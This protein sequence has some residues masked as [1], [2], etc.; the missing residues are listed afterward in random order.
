MEEKKNNK[1]LIWL[2]VILIILI[3]G[4]IGFIVYDN[5]KEDKINNI[6]TTTR[7]EEANDTLEENILRRDN[8]IYELNNK[9]HTI[10][11]LYEK[12]NINE[13]NKINSQ[14][15]DVEEA[16]RNGDY[17]Y[18]IIYTKILI[19][20]KYIN[21]KILVYYDFENNLDNF[22]LLTRDNINK[23]K[24]ENEEYFIFEIQHR[25]SDNIF[26]DGG[27]NPFIVDENGSI[28]HELK[29]D[30]ATGWGTTDKNSIMYEKGMYSIENNNIYYLMPN[31]EKT[32]PDTV[33]FNQYSLEIKDSKVY[34]RLMG[35]YEGYVAGGDICSNE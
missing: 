30:D 17:L 12:A 3:L 23:I 26:M 19:D 35:I 21:K 20:E 28:I 27:T 34:N 6:T 1:G 16:K 13:I 33:Y 7:V 31:C 4:L 10:T 5:L 14:I 32:T 11:F 29:F 25:N 22:P 24:G 18:N 8:F 2:I 15:E 9:K